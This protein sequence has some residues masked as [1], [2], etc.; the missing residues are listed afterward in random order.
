MSYDYR[1]EA[2]RTVN[3]LHGS[4]GPLDIAGQEAAVEAFGRVAGAAE[5]RAA[6]AWY[7]DPA[8]RHAGG[9]WLRARA[10]EIERG[11]K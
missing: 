1:G 10:D 9:F 11:D 8:T 2:Q 7:D 5:L 4:G 6:A 3:R